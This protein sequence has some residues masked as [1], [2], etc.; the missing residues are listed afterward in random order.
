M[1]VGLALSIFIINTAAIVSILGARTAAVRKLGWLMAVVLLPFAGAAGW[2]AA[3]RTGR[4]RRHM[5]RTRARN[6]R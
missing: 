3:G 4:R 6:D 2:A 1:R 5:T